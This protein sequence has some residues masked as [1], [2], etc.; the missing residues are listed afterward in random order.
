MHDVTACNG[1][2]NVLAND[3]QNVQIHGYNRSGGGVSKIGGGISKMGGGY[4]KSLLIMAGDEAT[5]G[6]A[7]QGIDEA[8]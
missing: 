1:L 5:S 6:R 8:D 4:S 2:Q 7:T 3:L